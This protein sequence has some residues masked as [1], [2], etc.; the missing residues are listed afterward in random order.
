MPA[1]PKYNKH[2]NSVQKTLSPWVRIAAFF[3]LH[4]APIPKEFERV[5][6]CGI[7]A[8]NSTYGLFPRD[9]WICIFSFLDVDDLIKVQLVSKQWYNL[10]SLQ[11]LI[12]V[13][14]CKFESILEA[15]VFQIS[16]KNQ[17]FLH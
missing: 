17:R 12:K 3:R 5:E 11:F 10:I 7:P 9:I 2:Y 1:I 14:T 16:S 8:N 4:F 6:L 13:Q 15:S